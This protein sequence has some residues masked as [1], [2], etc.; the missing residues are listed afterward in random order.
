MNTQ[1]NGCVCT[2]DEEGNG[3][4]DVCTA[5]QEWA[6]IKLESLETGLLKI[7]EIALAKAVKESEVAT[8]N[9]IAKEAFAKGREG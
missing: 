5:H 7:R 4:T 6:A 9:E 2:F 3:P 1:V 8:I